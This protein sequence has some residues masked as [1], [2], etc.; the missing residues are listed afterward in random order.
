MSTKFFRTKSK[1]RDG[2]E[3][4]SV[5]PKERKDSMRQ[6]F[7]SYVEED[8]NAMDEKESETDSVFGRE[9]REV[10][11]LNVVTDLDE[12]IMLNI[13]DGEFNGSFIKTEIPGSDSAEMK[14]KAQSSEK[15]KSKSQLSPK[16][17][18]SPKR[19]L[20]LTE[21]VFYQVPRQSTGVVNAMSFDGVVG[22]KE[23]DNDQPFYSNLDKL[24]E[25]GHYEVPK[26]RNSLEDVS[27]YS[28][29]SDINGSNIT[30]SRVPLYDNAHQAGAISNT[31]ETDGDYIDMQGAVKAVLSRE[32]YKSCSAIEEKLGAKYENTLQIQTANSAPTSPLLTRSQ[33][34]DDSSEND[35]HVTAT[36][37][38]TDEYVGP[39]PIEQ[40]TAKAPKSAT[41]VPYIPETDPRRTSLLS[42][43]PTRPFVQYTVEE[44][45]EC[46]EMC[47]L[48]QVAKVCTEE[49][50][51]G[52]YFK[53]LSDDDLAAEPFCL[54]Q[55]HVTKVRK[56]ISGWRP[57]RL[58][59]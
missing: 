40:E 23:S 33:Q 11:T 8:E 6:T 21:D 34:E 24:P 30:E 9:K 51:D 47:A 45:V 5:K 13:S 12:R 31:F 49:S 54:S 53:D 26:S 10:D 7:I 39:D 36:I 44:V 41:V 38:E 37:N 15:T 19:S 22:E 42:S 1:S 58:T 3:S 27:L 2:R 43:S 48:P 4:D 29:V 57:K 46:F 55:F 52:E 56:I 14:S 28:D 35:R 32:K 50:L 18:L 20:T 17:P 59:Y 25:S 16:H